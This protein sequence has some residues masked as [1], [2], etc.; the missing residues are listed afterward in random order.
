MHFTSGKTH[1][2]EREV[3]VFNSHDDNDK[4]VTNVNV[5]NV[6]VTKSAVF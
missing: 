5:T 1:V 6:N 3:E 2:T 4:N